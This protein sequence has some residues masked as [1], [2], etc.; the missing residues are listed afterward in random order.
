MQR[1][2]SWPSNT[3][4]VNENE[5]VLENGADDDEDEFLECESS[6]LIVREESV[7]KTN[8]LE[9]K[10]FFQN[11]STHNINDDSVTS[12][13]DIGTTVDVAETNDVATATAATA[14]TDN[15]CQQDS[16]VLVATTQSVGT[17]MSRDQLG[18]SAFFL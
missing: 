13:A 10:I 1:V 15:W 5:D 12:V 4:I 16:G 8:H 14:T 18:V 9:E 7:P 11:N 3:S 17:V 6:I 2:G